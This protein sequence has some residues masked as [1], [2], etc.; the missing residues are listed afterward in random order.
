[1]L[2]HL[3][4]PRLSEKIIRNKKMEDIL[5]FY[6]EKFHKSDKYQRWVGCRKMIVENDFSGKEFS[7]GQDF[8]NWRIIFTLERGSSQIYTNQGLNPSISVQA[9]LIED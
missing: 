8:S 9:S 7:L 3:V 1:M 5:S 6:Y 4:K 2:I